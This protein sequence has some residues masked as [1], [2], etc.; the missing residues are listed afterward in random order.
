[1]S[2]I[3]KSVPFHLQVYEIIKEKILSG[4]LKGGE[5]IYENKISQELGV[6]RSPV[7]EALRMLEQDEFLVY[8]PPS[9]LIVNPMNFEY[10]E[11]IYQ[12]RMAV[13]PFA[14]RLA[15][16]SIRE[17]DISTLEQCVKEAKEYHNKK[18][19]SKVIEV[20]TRFHDLIVEKCRNS[21][22]KAFIQ[23]TRT[24]AILSRVSEFHCY[25]REDGYLAEHEAILEAINM[26]DE[27]ELEKR[28]R[29]HIMNDYVFYKEQLNK[30][31]L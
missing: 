10:M 20:N 19:F 18:Q 29:N 30:Q 13:E 4:E 22:L 3:Q 16:E 11:E 25:Q 14:A 24:L 27:N 17:E 6:S 15:L 23:K 26:K 2:N 12:C 1:M 31:K 21:R 5:R 8:N 28:L 7:R 9:G